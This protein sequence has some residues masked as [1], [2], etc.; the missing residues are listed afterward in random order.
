V[1]DVVDDTLLLF[2]PRGRGVGAATGRARPL[3]LVTS[4]TG[5]S[6][7]TLA[8]PSMPQ[9]E[10]EP[11]RALHTLQ[12]MPYAAASVTVEVQPDQA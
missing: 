1:R 12:S 5:R 3:A 10:E 2:G 4:S 6:Y 7:G 9:D 8:E 11:A